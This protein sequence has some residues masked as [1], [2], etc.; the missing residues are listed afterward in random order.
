MIVKFI[1]FVLGA[2]AS[3]YLSGFYAGMN[4]ENPAEEETTAT[5]SEGGSYGV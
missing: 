3:N 4:C 5:G 1:F 2:L